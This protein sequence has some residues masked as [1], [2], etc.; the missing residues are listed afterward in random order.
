M[1]ARTVSSCGISTAFERRRLPNDLD[2]ER[3]LVAAMA[4]A[5]IP[6]CL[7]KSRRVFFMAL[8]GVLTATEDYLPGA[9]SGAV[10]GCGLIRIANIGSSKVRRNR[11]AFHFWTAVPRYSNSGFNGSP[12]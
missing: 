11:L 9:V 2:G 3:V 8:T 7:M 6:V 12:V 10:A 5:A 4:A 1:S